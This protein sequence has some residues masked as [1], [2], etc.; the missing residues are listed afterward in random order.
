MGAEGKGGEFGGGLP[1]A[2]ISDKGKSQNMGQF[3]A[4]L[5]SFGIRY[6]YY[7]PKDWKCFMY[8][9]PIVDT[10][11]DYMGGLSKVIFGGATPEL[12]EEF[13]KDDGIALKVVRLIERTLAHS[14]GKFIAGDKMSIADFIACSFI[15]NY[16]MNDAFHARDLSLLLSMALLLPP[17]SSLLTEPSS[18][19]S[20]RSGSTR[21]LS[22]SQC[23][24]DHAG[25]IAVPPHGVM[26]PGGFSLHDHQMLK[27]LVE[28]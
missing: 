21:D 5:R 23:S 18:S 3:G 19:M 8:V 6:G 28:N 10:W 27:L 2:N 1:Q 14:P 7:N 13:V 20:A 24:E 12:I 17:P 22:H 15:A 16:L 26:S 4:I 9:D 11:A 25:G